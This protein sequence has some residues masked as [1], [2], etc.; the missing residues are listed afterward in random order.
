MT[1]TEY[2]FVVKRKNDKGEVSYSNYLIPKDKISTVLEGLLY[3]R[4]NLDKT[5]SVRY[6]CRMEICGSC[7]MEINGKP[8][9]A[10][11]TIAAK[12]GKDRI[13]VE[14]LKHY[15]VIKDLVVDMDPFFTKYRDG[16]PFIIREDEGD[17]TSELP[18]TPDQFKEYEKYSMCIKCGICLAACPIAGS[19]PDYIGPAALAGV[20]RYNLDNR[21][22]GKK[23]RLEIVDG[24]EG[25]SRCHFAGECTEAC[26]KGVDPSFAIQLL[27]AQGT[28]YE[29][30]KIFR[31]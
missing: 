23:Y 15:D 30:A 5:L 12:L 13:T 11:S 8:K 31:R 27:R 20:L 14:P 6:S 22:Q 1:E 18:Q 29:L 4:D 19:D 10:C 9:T 26:P 7:G 28:R 21:D 24:E 2:E 25:T 17:Y 16:L 3:I